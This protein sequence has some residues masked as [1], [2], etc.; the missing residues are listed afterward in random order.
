MN[1]FIAK[2]YLKDLKICDDIVD[3]VKSNS[4]LLVCGVNGPNKNINVNIKE[5]LDLSANLLPEDIKNNY[6][7]ELSI[8]LEKY[9]QKYEFS[10]LGEI[11]ILESPNI[12]Y[13]KPGMHFKKFH[14]EK[15]FDHLRTR[16]DIFDRFISRHL[17]WMTYLNDVE[18]GG[19]TEF[20]YQK[21]KIKPE[22]GLTLIWPAEWTHTHRG[23]IANEDKFII[24]GW[25]NLL[26]CRNKNL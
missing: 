18:D 16:E 24:T 25:L 21:L 13:Y 17:V 15:S 12:Q 1:N 19:E 3:F 20:Y 11:S 23:L 4:N 14:C 10:Y 6:F 8:F 9:L 7:S 26:T 5:S 2:F 22:K